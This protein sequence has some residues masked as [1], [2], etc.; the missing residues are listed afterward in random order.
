MKSHFLSKCRLATLTLIAFI[1]SSGWATVI[2]GDLEVKARDGANGDLKVAGTT[3]LKGTNVNGDLG[4]S[5]SLTV[6]GVSNASVP[7]GV[8]VMWSG[9]TNKIPD[10]WALCNGADGR[11]DLRGR[12]IVGYSD[13]TSDTR[14]DYKKI[15]NKGGNDSKELTL[16]NMPE[17]KHNVSFTKSGAHRHS[18]PNG[19]PKTFLAGRQGP[20]TQNVDTPNNE[21][22][23]NTKKDEGDHDHTIDEELK[24]NNQ[25]FDNRPAYYVLAYIIKL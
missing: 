19:R 13:D 2:E 9:D 7:R 11:P 1:S 12:F 14:S 15:G 3:N 20:Y 21:N 23:I 8:I 18:I 4:V 6:G 16:D 10:G 5:G 17:H 25:A 22:D 24:G